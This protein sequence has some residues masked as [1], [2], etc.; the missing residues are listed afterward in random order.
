MACIENPSMMS[1]MYPLSILCYALTVDP[2][3]HKNYWSIV[4][5][6]ALIQII[7]KYLI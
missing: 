1:V 4:L 7:M 6:Y 5:F 3:P 2:R